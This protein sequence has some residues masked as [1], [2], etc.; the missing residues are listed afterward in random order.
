MT[1]PNNP[2][3]QSNPEA[4]QEELADTMFLIE[5]MFEEPLFRASVNY[6]STQYTLNQEQLQIDPLGDRYKAITF[7]VSADTSHDDDHSDGL[8][9]VVTFVHRNDIGEEVALGD[10][11]TITPEQP[12]A[13]HDVILK[14]FFSDNHVHGWALYGPELEILDERA[15]SDVPDAFMYEDHLVAVK[16][17]LSVEVPEDVQTGNTTVS[18]EEQQLIERALDL[19]KRTD[20][21]LINRIR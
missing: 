11:T 10:M 6:P 8:V 15:D 12:G 13:M 21:L 14:Q 4:S 19:I 1:S 3:S 5:E 20:P 7:D 16:G 9:V 17:A 2:P 18:V